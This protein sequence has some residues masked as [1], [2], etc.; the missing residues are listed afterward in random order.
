MDQV[1]KVAGILSLLIAISCNNTVRYQKELSTVDSLEQLVTGYRLKIDSLDLAEL[2]TS[3]DEVDTTLQQ[4]KEAGVPPENKDFWVTQ[5]GPIANINKAMRRFTENYENLS[6]QLEFSKK[7]LEA[8]E[9][10]IEDEKLDSAEVTRYVA[11]ESAAVNVLKFKVYKNYYGAK[12]AMS[13][14]SNAKSHYDSLVVAVAK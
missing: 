14:W 10:S 8:L 7:Q 5:M 4:L 13:N 9:N 3:Y 12:E 11:E 2:Q 1:K 6:E